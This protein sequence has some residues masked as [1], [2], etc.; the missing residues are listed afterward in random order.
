MKNI[1]QKLKSNHVRMFKTRHL[2]VSIGV[3]CRNNR[4]NFPCINWF[5]SNNIVCG[6]ELKIICKELFNAWHGCFLHS[7]GQLN[8][9]L[10]LRYEH[11][12]EHRQR[13]R[14]ILFKNSWNALLINKRYNCWN[15]GAW[16][17]TA[18]FHIK[19]GFRKFFLICIQLLKWMN[20][21][22]GHQRC[23]T[24]K[25]HLNLIEFRLRL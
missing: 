4:D 19:D 14:L 5:E 11:F 24:I 2:P 1:V 13:Q 20:R 23:W 21:S 3:F 9:W 17:I 15:S 7:N 25:L 22:A 8:A 10:L 12:N 16:N 6:I 18:I